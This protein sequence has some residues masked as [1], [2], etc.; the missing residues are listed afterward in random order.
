[1]TSPVTNR[2]FLLDLA[3]STFETLQSEPSALESVTD[4]H[5]YAV[6][7]SLEAALEARLEEPAASEESVAPSS[8]AEPYIPYNQTLSLLQSAY[9]EY[10]ES[11]GIT[12]MAFDPWDP[13]WQT[14]AVEKLKAASRGKHPFVSHRSPESFRY[15][16][17]ADATVALF[18]DWGTGETT[19]QRVM[20]QVAAAHPTHAIHLGDVYY[21]GTPKEANERFLDIIDRFGPSRD[22][23]R[24]LSLAGNHDYYSGGY[25]YY[26]STLP[27]LNQEASYFNLRN[28]KWQIIGLDTGY[29]EYGLQDPQ[30]EWLTAQLRA[31]SLKSIMLSH[32]Q[33]FSAYDNRVT[34]STILEKTKTLLPRI[35]AWFWGHEHRCVIM[36][37]HMG[38]RARCI[39]HG[40]IP[41]TVPYG[42]PVFPDVTVLKVD[43]RA[44][45]DS[46]GTCYHG[47]ALL[48]FNEA[49]VNVSYIDEYGNKFYEEHF[50]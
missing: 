3:K 22:A 16:L 17:P 47:S 15:D 44:A 49:Q 33:L 32:H 31:P 43:E 42:K 23:C 21:A 6:K 38:I 29:Q 35:Y 19:A 48:Q 39:G 11:R 46:E 37:D 30:L 28:G 34:K 9:E 41:S 12:E 13:G 24:Y 10:L 1:M 20:Q 27:A 40:A 26:D 8:S 45:P 4:V 18:A 14:I 5:P 25:A 36:G 50:E 7:K 2:Q